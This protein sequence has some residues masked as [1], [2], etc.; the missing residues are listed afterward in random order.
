[1]KFARARNCLKLVLVVVC[2][3]ATLSLPSQA[4]AASWNGRLPTSSTTTTSAVITRYSGNVTPADVLNGRRENILRS[5]KEVQAPTTDRSRRYKRDL[6][7]LVN[8]T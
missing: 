7:Q 2:L 6:T 5:K 1:V 8:A 4:S 3:T